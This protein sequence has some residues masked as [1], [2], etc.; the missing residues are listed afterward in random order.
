M[1]ERVN[2]TLDSNYINIFVNYL[3]LAEIPTS[4]YFNSIMVNDVLKLNQMI[5]GNT[6][7]KEAKDIAQN[8]FRDIIE[9]GASNE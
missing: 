5:D 3:H 4:R 9:K 7:Y 2:I 6:K 1:K 8:Y